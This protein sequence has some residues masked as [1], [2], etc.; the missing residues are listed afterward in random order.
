MGRTQKISNASCNKWSWQQAQWLGK[1]DLDHVHILAKARQTTSN[2][3][4]VRLLQEVLPCMMSF[5]GL[6]RKQAI[7]PGRRP[8]SAASSEAYHI[9]GSH[10]G[11]CFN[12]ASLQRQRKAVAT[13]P[14]AIPT[15]TRISSPR[16][17]P[18]SCHCTCLKTR[19]P[20]MRMLLA[21]SSEKLFLL[22][23]TGTLLTTSRQRISGQGTIQPT[24]SYAVS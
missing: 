23:D 17:S 21:S 5:L 11:S 3:F 18:N 4:R 8:I 2:G 16:A 22:A 13:I 9:A 20:K 14:S 1:N 12:C 7:L 19:L 24:S 10:S 15:Y 6:L